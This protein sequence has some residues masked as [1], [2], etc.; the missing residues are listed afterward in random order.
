MDEAS[1]QTGINAPAVHVK[2]KALMI[3]FNAGSAEIILSS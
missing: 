1:F 3:P 2:R